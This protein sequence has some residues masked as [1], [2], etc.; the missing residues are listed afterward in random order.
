MPAWQWA[1]CKTGCRYNPGSSHLSSIAMDE[2]TAKELQFLRKAL[3]ADAECGTKAFLIA[4]AMHCK[5]GFLCMCKPSLPGPKHSRQPL[6][7]R[8]GGGG[9]GGGRAGANNLTARCFHGSGL[10]MT[11]HSDQL[12]ARLNRFDNAIG[13]REAKVSRQSTSCQVSTCQR[14]RACPA[15]FEIKLSQAIGTIPAISF[16]MQAVGT[17]SNLHEV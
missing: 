12:S 7:E 15:R 16:Q 13:S 10:T 9:G 8:R 1:L 4:Y 2:Q 14:H 6:K 5:R 3:G 17:V 11:A